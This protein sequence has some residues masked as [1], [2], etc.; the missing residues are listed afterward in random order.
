MLVFYDEKLFVQIILYTFNTGRR[1]GIAKYIEL[2]III[3]NV[4][5]SFLCVYIYSY[6]NYD[7]YEYISRFLKV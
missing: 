6:F 4:H 2:L 3:H 5:G 1:Q 7:F